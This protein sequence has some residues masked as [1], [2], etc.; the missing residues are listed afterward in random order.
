MPS[1]DISVEV[2]LG[3]DAAGEVVLSVDFS[4]GAGS[5]AHMGSLTYPGHPADPPEV[6]IETIF[7]PITRYDKATNKHVEDHIEMPES[8]LPL[9]VGDAILDQ[10]IE[11]Y[12]PADDWEDA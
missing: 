10:I 4:Y 11:K 1:M 6:E 2:C 7:W 5:P 12:D 3:D 8:G 9:S